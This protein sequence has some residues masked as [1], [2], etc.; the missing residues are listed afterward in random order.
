M[1]S[2]DGS[3]CGACNCDCSVRVQTEYVHL[4]EKE[5]Q[6]YENRIDALEKELKK[7]RKINEK[8]VERLLDEDLD[9]D[10]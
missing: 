9:L 1:P 7:Q 8:L 3:N 2:C 4:D 10:R 6:K 5:R